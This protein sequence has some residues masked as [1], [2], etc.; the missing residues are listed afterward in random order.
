MRITGARVALNAMKA[1]KADLRL[2]RGRVSFLGT[3]HSP[4]TVLDFSGY[5]ILPGLINSHDHLE[6]NL[7]P[8]L[9]RGI[10]PNATAWATD[11]YQPGKSPIS[12]QLAVPTS[13]RLRWGAIKN[14][15]SGVTTVAHHNPLPSFALRRKLPVRVL[16]RY[17]WAHSVHFAPDWQQRFQATPKAYPFIIHAGEGTD[18]LSR[19][20]IKL[21]KQTGVLNSSTVLVHAVGVGRKE[22]MTIAESGSSLVWCPS[23]NHFTLGQSV[24]RKILNAGLPIALG[25]D[26][27]LTSKGDLLDELRFASVIISPERLYAMVT[28]TAA[29]V[30]KL[31]YGFGE[32]CHGGPADL[33]IV[34]DDGFTPAETL[35]HAI[36]QAVIV[37]GRFELVS[38]SF[39]LRNLNGLLKLENRGA[40]FLRMP[41]AS[42]TKETREIL[43]SEVRLA[44]KLVA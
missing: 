44:G 18:E 4:Q 43:G 33:L 16:S 17:G 8:R 5:M 9:G 34:R 29:Q 41:T 25:T 42:L 35:L 23:S 7:F 3:E 37:K 28:S 24:D 30:L 36:P 32:I 19:R 27:A 40:Y 10:Y 15:L 11:I 26:S 1:E 12:E 2:N 31:P 20:E 13:A 21:L 38:A 14:L 6:L 22:L 39:R